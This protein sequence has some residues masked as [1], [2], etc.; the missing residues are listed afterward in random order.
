VGARIGQF[1]AAFCL[2]VVCAGCATGL[3]G[4]AS[5]STPLVSHEASA[6]PSN[7]DGSAPTP[8]SESGPESGSEPGAPF[9][10]TP[11]ELRALATRFVTAALAYEPPPRGSATS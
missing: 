3:G 2:V 11:Q 10:E 1:A 5:P 6:I 9:A 8:G 4:S 7:V